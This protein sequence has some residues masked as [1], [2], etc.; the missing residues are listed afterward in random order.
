MKILNYGSQLLYR[1][2]SLNSFKAQNLYGLERLTRYK[3]LSAT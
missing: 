1:L 2:Y 3:K